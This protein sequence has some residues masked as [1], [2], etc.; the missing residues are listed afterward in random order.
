[1]HHVHRLSAATLLVALTVSLLAMPATAA[2]TSSGC[3]TPAS[4]DTNLTLTSPTATGSTLTGTTLDVLAAWNTPAWAE[5][6]TLWMC[7]T[8]SASPNP[9]AS[10]GYPVVAQD[11]SFSTALTVPSDLA[12][13]TDLCVR[14][15]LVGRQSD[16]TPATE[17]SNALCF[18]TA[19]TSSPSTTTTV[20][21]AHRR[22]PARPPRPP[23]PLPSRPPG[24]RRRR[25]VRPPY[26]PPSPRR[27]RRDPNSPAPDGPSTSSP[28]SPRCSWLSGPYFASSDAAG[29]CPSPRRT[30]T[31][32]DSIDGG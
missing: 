11:G 6:A 15:V 8:T 29:P 12:P 1:M 22:R 32:H 13:G 18:R 17:T 10:S 16:T 7:L 21:T 25:V 20:T 26:S 23:Q 14:G 31:F 28:V 9:A 4:S 5:K 24:P 19:A 2:S 30:V 27:L 3:T